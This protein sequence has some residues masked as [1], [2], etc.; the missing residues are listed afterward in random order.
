MRTFALAALGVAAI[1][2]GAYLVSLYSEI[3]TM[4]AQR[5]AALSSSILSAPHAIRIGDD[6]AHSRLLER[7]TSLSYSPLAEARTPGEYAKSASRIAI[8]LRGFRQG[9]KRFDSRRVELLLDGG[10]I[11]A[12]RDDR[13]AATTA[14]LEPQA[15]GRLIAGTSAERVEIELANQKPYLVDGLLATEDQFFYWHPGFN[16]VRIAA[17]ALHDLKQGRLAA[18]ASTLTQQL[19]RTF[20][21]RRERTFERKLRELAVAIVLELRLSKDQILE[22]Y[23]NDVSMG[24]FEGAPIHGMPQAARYFFNKD[25]GQVT[26]AEAATLIGMVQAPTMYDPRRYAEASTRRRDVVLAVMKR[27]GVIDDA[28]YGAAIATPIKLTKPPGLRRAPYFSDYVI[29][30]LARTPG[31][32]GNLTGLKVFTTLDTEIQADAVDALT[33]NVDR[34]E[35]NFRGLRRTADANKL[36]TSAVVL[37]A[38]TGAIR[39]LVGGRDYSVSQ[40]NRAASALRQPGSAFKPFVYLAAMDPARATVSPVLTLASMLPNQPMSFGGWSPE[41]Y[42]RHADTQVTALKAMSQSLNIPAAYIGSRLGAPLMVRTAHELGIPQHLEA[43]L[44]IAIGAE[45]TTLLDLAAAYQPFANAGVRAPAYAIEAV[46]DVDDREI[47]RHEAADSR[48]IDP[49]VAYIVTSALKSVMK[50]GTGASAGR[51]GLDFPAAGKTGTTQDY[52]DA[53]FV[54]YT[55]QIVCGVWL[56]FDAPQSLGL[57][58]AQAALPAW[59]GIM[60]SS[61]PGKLADFPEPAGIVKASIDPETGALATPSCPGRI[62]LPFLAGTAPTDH[63]S[64]HGG[65]EVASGTNRNW[66]GWKS[67]APV[68]RAKEEKKPNVFN[69]V[70][71]FFG[72]IFKR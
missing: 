61:V 53:I 6:V 65:A 3:S 19:A 54:G 27:D 30:T 16:P 39:A 2:T 57:T 60:K 5:R 9:D 55:P 46:V 8:Y 52:R 45:E 42:E 37:D 40:F 71:K 33:A 56:G 47:Y 22:R 13:G 68:A 12:I 36:Q 18:G 50:S 49:A 21:E 44:P 69:K 66:G 64:S 62:T 4:L 11:V 51:L 58:S 35:K 32:D 43:V 1:A 23:I 72:S 14:M 17:A 48:V 38:E 67:T 63:C 26:P 70:G 25:L 24:A 31:F 29:S 15:I 59:V 10:E 28:A 41:N 20:M 7:L 34:L